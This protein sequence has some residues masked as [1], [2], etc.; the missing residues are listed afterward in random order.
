MTTTRDPDSDIDFCKFVETDYEERFV[1]LFMV[2]R[3]LV[4]EK[5]VVRTLNRRISG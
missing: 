3:K 1:D 5:R 2:M 4:L